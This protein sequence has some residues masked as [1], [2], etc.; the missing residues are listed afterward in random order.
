MKRKTL[1]GLAAILCVIAIIT[2]VSGISENYPKDFIRYINGDKIKDPSKYTKVY[3]NVLVLGVF[4]NQKEIDNAPLYPHTGSKKIGAIYK[5]ND[6]YIYVGENGEKEYDL[7][8]APYSGNKL[9]DVL[10]VMTEHMGMPVVSAKAFL[11]FGGALFKN[12]D[13]HSGGGL[14]FRNQ[15]EYGIIDYEQATLYAYPKTFSQ[16]I[17]K[18]D[19]YV[20]NKGDNFPYFPEN[21]IE[22][23]EGKTEGKLEW[24]FRFGSGESRIKKGSGKGHLLKEYLLKEQLTKEEYTVVESSKKENPS[25]METPL[26]SIT[27]SPAQTTPHP[28]PTTT[29]PPPPWDDGNGGGG[30]NL[31]GVDFTNVQLNYISYNTSIDKEFNTFNYIFK[32]KKAEGIVDL[33]DETEK[34]L[35]SFSI[36]LL[37]PAS[38]FWVNLNP[39]EPDRI[40]EKDLKTTDVG[41]IMLQ[42]DLQMKKDFSRYEDPC[43]GKTGIEFWNLLNEKKDKLVKE[44]IVKHPGE[45]KDVNDVQFS[46]VT[47]H[48]IV[49]DKV[50][51]YENDNEIYIINSTMNISSEPVSEQSRY[52]VNSLTLS[53]SSKEDLDQAAKEYGK[54][55]K[56]LQEKKILPLVV[57]E[58]NNGKNYSDLRQ[59]YNSLA[60]AQWYKNKNRQGSSLFSEFIDSKQLD[61]LEAKTAWNAIDVWKDY[62]KSFEEGDYHCWKNNTYQQENYEITESKLYSGGGVDF[63]DIK[64]TNRGDIPDNLKETLSEAMFSLYAKE[65]ND[66]YFGD[67]LYIYED[68]ELD[69]SSG[70]SEGHGNDTKN[71]AESETAHGHIKPEYNESKTEAVDVP[72]NQTDNIKTKKPII[73]A[74]LIVI[75]VI[76]TA[77]VIY[78]AGKRD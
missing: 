5:S 30:G 64:I 67:G 71:I 76:L 49:P 32:V 4:H 43:E 3:E 44:L 40:I 33:E 2:S 20:V 53:K 61:G 35:I 15:V 57:H 78:M 31:G 63:M 8:I 55:V 26:P 37:I 41:R 60:L 25:V 66:Y 28:I 56:E 54:Y 74:A 50:V 45:I 36:G 29:I 77:I 21:K 11:P 38:E 10:L 1:A 51:A 58:V 65:G 18:R 16:E 59:V 12:V 62:K 48:W 69:S 22:A 6:K 23:K 47:R 7:V 34:S 19:T 46:P 52:I 24:T 72:G 73:F 75:G 13:T 68:N 27:V 17:D 70:G 14:A 9:A 42:A 39:L